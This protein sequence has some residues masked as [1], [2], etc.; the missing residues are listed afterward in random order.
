M[1]GAAGI[2]LVPGAGSTEGTGCPCCSEP[3]LVLSLPLCTKA[4]RIKSLQ[5]KL[6]DDTW[7]NPARGAPRAEGVRGVTAELG[8]TMGSPGQLQICTLWGLLSTPGTR[9]GDEG[10]CS[11]GTGGWEVTGRAETPGE[12]GLGRGDGDRCLLNLDPTDEKKKKKI[13][14]LQI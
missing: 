5:V 7:Q 14:R 9:R 1:W 10:E 8:G 12:A 11:H 2:S 3:A 6:A 4:S 13:C